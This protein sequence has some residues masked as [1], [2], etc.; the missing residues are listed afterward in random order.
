MSNSPSLRERALAKNHPPEKLF[1]L[2]D[3]SP[4]SP[5]EQALHT[6]Y[7]A[8]LPQSGHYCLFKLPSRDH[9]WAESIEELTQRVEEFGTEGG[10]YFAV[11]SFKTAE[12]RTQANVLSLCALR[13]DVDAGAD[14]FRRDPSGVYETRELALRAIMVFIKASGIEP[15]YIVSSGEGWHLYY[16]LTSDLTPEEWKPLSVALGKAAQGSGL[17]IDPTVTSDTARVLRPLGTTHKNG[18]LVTLT[19]DTGARYEPATLALT[20]GAVPQAPQR[21]FDMSVNDDLDLTVK[22]PPKSIHKI[23]QHCGAMKEINAVKGDVQEPFWRAMLGVV[24]FTVEGVEA[25]QMLSTGHQDYDEVSTERKFNAWATGPTTCAELGKHTN[26]CMSCEYRGN[27]KSPILL[28]YLTAPEVKKLPLEQQPVGGFSE[29]EKRPRAAL[30]QFLPDWFITADGEKVRPQ[31][32]TTNFDALA[33]SHGVVLAYNVMTKR[34]ETTMP[35]LKVQRDDH[36]NA[37]LAILGDLA[38]RA[39]M[40]RNGI[41]EL[42]DTVAGSNPFH[43]VKNSIEATPWDGTSRLTILHNTLVLADPSQSLLRDQLMDA[44]ALQCIGA[45]YEPSGIAAQGVLV[46]VGDQGCGKTRWFANLSNVPG[47]VRLGIHLN[48]MDKDSVIQATNGWIGEFGEL[49]STTKKAEQSALKAFI[50][51][52]EDTLRPA[53]ARKENVY[54]RR[55]V[56]GG[57]VNGTGFLV[58]STGDRRFW[59]VHVKLCHLLL[60]DVV[61]QIWAEYLAKYLAGERWHLSP[62]TKD[63]LNEANEAHRAIDPIRER[64]LTEFDWSSVIWETVSEDDRGRVNWM[65]ATEICNRIGLDR[66]TRSD[67]TRAG[68]IVCNLNRATSRKSNGVKLLGVPTQL[69]GGG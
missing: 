35:G 68:S 48:P 27:V 3:P 16:C 34:A 66:P 24:K 30:K 53:Y 11:E 57:S 28:G 15:S 19:A 52:N 14:K 46:L 69:G 58:D 64:I 5:P 6:F 20:L 1:N 7:Q 17:L 4:E 40:T 61:Q 9:I 2:F 42:S 41:Q 65:T 50:T 62:E 59:T 47:A 10:V 31:N 39:G 21:K 60:P 8:V 67:A 38:V 51:N 54:R 32:T 63:L 37:A 33:K 45:L 55:T 43:P 44:W 36:E 23:L 49:D 12:N 26:A 13:L 56:F 25:A 29:L 18:N 22:G